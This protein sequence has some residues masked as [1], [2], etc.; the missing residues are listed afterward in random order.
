[1][2]L[3]WHPSLTA[4]NLSYTS[5]I[6]ETSA[7]ALCGTTGKSWLDQ[8]FPPSSS[9]QKARKGVVATDWPWLSNTTGACSWNNRKRSDRSDSK[10]SPH[11]VSTSRW[12]FPWA[13]PLRT[14]PFPP[15]HIWTPTMPGPRRAC[16]W[17]RTWKWRPHWT[18]NRFRGFGVSPTTFPSLLASSICA[19]SE[20]REQLSIL[21]A[22]EL[23]LW[24]ST[25]CLR[26]QK[27]GGLEGPK[28]KSRSPYF[29]GNLPRSSNS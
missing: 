9:I 10:C 2:F 14:P 16:A 24:V 6:L 11:P 1:M 22:G 23:R 29:V 27:G 4:I 5:P 3:L 17:P 7:T 12:S 8:W 15:A 18:W 13:T 28:G 20:K 19:S 26:S 21:G 25:Q